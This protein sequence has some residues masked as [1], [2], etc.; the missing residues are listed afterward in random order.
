MKARDKAWELYSNYFDIVAKAAPSTTM[1]EQHYAAINSSL[2]AVDE[3]LTYAP[4]D[5]VHD[6]DGTGEFYSVKAYYHHVKNEVMK[7]NK[8]PD[9]EKLGTDYR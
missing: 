7:L 3:A 8:T 6:F 2:H 9:T 4:D 1:V 5:I